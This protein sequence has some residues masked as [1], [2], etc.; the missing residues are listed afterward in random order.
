MG[1][2]FSSTLLYCPYGLALN[3]AGN[4]YAAN[5][6]GQNIAQITPGGTITTFVSSGVPYPR[7][8]FLHT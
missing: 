5:F 8:N 1:T 4:L 6:K 2:V 3:A 7:V